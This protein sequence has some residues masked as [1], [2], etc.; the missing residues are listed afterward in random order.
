MD[1]F[2]RGARTNPHFCRLE[3][4]SPVRGG[5]PVGLHH[6]RDVVVKAELLR[7]NL[8]GD[9]FC[10]RG[11]VTDFIQLLLLADHP[12]IAGQ[13]EVSVLDAVEGGDVSAV[14]RSQAFLVKLADRLLIACAS[15]CI[16]RVC[17]VRKS[18]CAKCKYG[19]RHS[20][21]EPLSPCHNPAS[22]RA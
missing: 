20:Y 4:E 17:S 5:G 19:E 21:R 16:R 3:R 11:S 10:L 12:K 14:V 13:G 2:P 7:I 15:G 8:A 6:Q 9:Y 1:E 18:E 22:G